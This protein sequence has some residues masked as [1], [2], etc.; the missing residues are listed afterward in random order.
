VNVHL[1]PVRTY[2]I[3]TGGGVESRGHVHL[4]KKGYARSAPGRTY[5]PPNRARQS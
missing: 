5:G 3:G 4:K 2:L 1:A